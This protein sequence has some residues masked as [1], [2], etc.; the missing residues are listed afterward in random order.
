MAATTIRWSTFLHLTKSPFQFCKTSLLD[1]GKG[2]TKASLEIHARNRDTAV[3]TE[4]N[5]DL[6]TLICVL[7][8]RPRWCA[9]LSNPVPWQNWM[10]AYLGYTLCGWRRWFVADQ[11]WLV[12]L[13]REEE[14]EE[15]WKYNCSCVLSGLSN[16][17][18]K[19][20]KKRK[21]S[22]ES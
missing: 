17:F 19:F 16:K 12:K 7:V 21:I 15:D 6:Q 11:L 2:V 18:S 13:I 9:T 5:G 1:L 3:P 20:Y 14:E 8:A 22:P 10:V 4:G